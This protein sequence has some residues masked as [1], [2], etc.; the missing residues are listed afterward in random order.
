MS[1]LPTDSD[2]PNYKRPEFYPAYCKF[3]FY[4]SDSAAVI[5]PNIRIFNKIGDSYGYDIDN[6]Y[7]VDDASKVEFMLTAVVQSNEDGTYNDN[8]YEYATVC[9]PFMK[10]LGQLIYQHELTRPKKNLPNLKR[11]KK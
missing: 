1:M 11:F 7:I 8:K 10:N 5:K 2:Y 4:G 6:A 9:L 3:L